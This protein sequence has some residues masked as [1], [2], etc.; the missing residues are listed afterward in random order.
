MT[1]G[2]SEE[3]TALKEAPSEAASEAVPKETSPQVASKEDAPEDGRDGG[4]A[5]EQA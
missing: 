4:G 2:A 3:E 1:P 5:P